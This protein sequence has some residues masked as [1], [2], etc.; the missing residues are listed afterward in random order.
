MKLKNLFKRK[1][2]KKV[3]EGEVIKV[4]SEYIMELT[5]K[6][7]SEKN[8]MSKLIER[9]YSKELILKA[10]ELNLKKEVKNGKRKR[11]IRRRRL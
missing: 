2:K 10:F 4:I 9:G 7:H 6:K 11:R 1:K 8:I 5:K 3:N